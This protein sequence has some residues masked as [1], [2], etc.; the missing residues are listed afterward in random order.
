MPVTEPARTRP[1]VIDARTY[2]EILQFYARHF[3]LLDEGRAEEWADQFTEDGEFAQNVKPEPRRGRSAIAASMRRGMDSIAERGLIRRHWYGAVTAEPAGED[4]VRTRYY[5]TV[6]ETSRGG[7]E[8][9]VYLSTTAEDVLERRGDGW[10][11]RRRHVAH[12]GT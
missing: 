2:A 11:V 12:D 6:F 10:F 8:A 1:P 4:T 5:A 7:G 3:Q 9:R